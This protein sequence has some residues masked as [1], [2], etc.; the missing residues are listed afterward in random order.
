MFFIKDYNTFLIH[1][2][3]KE[4][5]IMKFIIDQI[6]TSSIP[7]WI[8]VLQVLLTLIVIQQTFQFYF[9]LDAV[10]AS[11]IE[12]T[13]IPDKNLVFEF[14]GRT[15]TMA[16]ISILIMLS[17]DVKLFIIMFVMNIFREGQE[18]IIDPLYPLANAPVSPTT[19]LILHIIIVSIEVIALLKLIAIYRSKK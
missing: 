19:D 12:V 7:I 16:I 1:S 3:P 17:Q 13:S 2:I 5:I 14:A 8:N 15:G 9:D 10:L 11:G 18:T 6:K 4:R